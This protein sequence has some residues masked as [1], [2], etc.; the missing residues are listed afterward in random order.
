MA[1]DNDIQWKNIKTLYGFTYEKG[2]GYELRIGKWV[3]NGKEGPAVLERREWWENNQ[4]TRMQG[5]QK[6]LAKEDL[7]RVV[8]MLSEVS[9][10]MGFPLP[11]ELAGP[12]KTEAPKNDPKTP[13]VPGG[14]F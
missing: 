5:K 12:T 14:R 13:P 9:Q 2:G 6:G 4:G 3:V 8:T 7:Y 11:S 1:G 10:L